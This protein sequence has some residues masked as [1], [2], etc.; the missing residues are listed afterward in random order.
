ML[1]LNPESSDYHQNLRYVRIPE[2]G[3]FRRYFPSIPRFKNF[4]SGKY[5]IICKRI[6]IPEKR[7]KTSRRLHIRK[8]SAELEIREFTAVT[9]NIRISTQFTLLKLK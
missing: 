9:S 1:Y 8:Y 7:K 3:L 2:S 6:T 5:R 4:Q